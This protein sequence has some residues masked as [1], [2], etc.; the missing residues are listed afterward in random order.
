ILFCTFHSFKPHKKEHDTFVEKP[1]QKDVSIL[2]TFLPFE[3]SSQEQEGE[4]LKYEGLVRK[5]FGEM[6]K[7]ESSTAVLLS[8]EE[9]VHLLQGSE[10]EKGMQENQEEEGME[11]DEKEEERN[12]DAIVEDEER[13]EETEDGEVATEGGEDAEENSQ[14]ESLTREASDREVEQESEKSD[15]AKIRV[16]VNDKEEDR[17]ET[18]KNEEEDEG[19]IPTIMED[20]DS[21]SASED[22]ERI[23]NLENRENKDQSTAEHNPPDNNNEQEENSQGNLQESKT[24]GDV[25]VAPLTGRGDDKEEND[26]NE[27]FS[28]T[29]GKR[30][31]QKKNQRK[32]KDQLQNDQPMSSEVTLTEGAEMD[33]SVDNKATKVKRKKS[34][35]WPSPVGVNPV[36]IRARVELFPSFKRIQSQPGQDP[37]VPNP[38]DAVRCKRG[39]VCKLTKEER[40]VCVCQE[41]SDCPASVHDL[42]H[43]C[44]TDNKTY[45][46][47]CELFAT[48]CI[49]EGTKRG[50]KLHLEYTGACKFIAPCQR[51]ELVQFPLRMRDWLKNVLL[52]LYEQDTVASGFLTSKQ[53]ARVQKIYE[54]E[55]R[56]HAGDHSI[57]LLVR[58]FE[59]NYPMY[60][61][62]V[63]WQFAQMDQHPPDHFL[64][65]SELAPLRVPLVPMEHCT[66][67]FFQ[68]CDA[69]KDKQV[70]F[71]EWC[72]CFGIK[73]EDMDTH[74]LF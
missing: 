24:S 21:Q 13:K 72:H 34:G 69:D 37:A 62:P 60:I 33:E 35:K 44:G 42:D 27:S 2:P 15:L 32:S 65:H 67:D 11:S 8:E 54:S 56:L 58:D 61:Y 46:T 47:S 9:L 39:K 28:H 1:N 43:V 49:L 20:Y 50:N 48:K 14:T 18:E 55:R 70:S 59:K 5:D 26:M 25:G 36:Q 7:D 68:E 3:A 30:R 45:D 66:S 51:S 16:P 73:E 41:P 12:E 74:L 10:E 19:E 57:E 38:C 63:H 22:T 40:P 17:D 4:G 31:K 53:R 71:K 29:K 23:Q 64:S 52:Q 6:E